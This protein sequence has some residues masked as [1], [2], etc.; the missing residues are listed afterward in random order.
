M[1]TQNFALPDS[2]ADE[3]ELGAYAAMRRQI[4][5]K[6]KELDAQRSVIRLADVF[7]KFTELSAFYAVEEQV[8]ND[9]GYD[10]EIRVVSNRGD[11]REEDDNSYGSENELLDVG[12]RYNFGPQER[13]LHDALRDWARSLPKSGLEGL[14]GKTIR[15]PEEGLLD[16]LAAQALAPGVYAAWQASILERHAEPAAKG[17]ASRAL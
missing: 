5:A 4:E 16:G 12:A 13:R 3:S 7:K 10:T 2:L 1:K 6:F 15:R 14:A 8:Y 17:P 9:E 11:D